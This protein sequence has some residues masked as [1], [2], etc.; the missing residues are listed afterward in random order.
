MAKYQQ[1]DRGAGND[2]DR[3]LKGMDASMRQKV[4]LTAA[5]LLCEGQIADM[6]MGSGTGSQALAALYPS[7]EVI[8]V[9][10]NQEMVDRAADRYK[11]SNLR[12]QQGDIAERCFSDQYLEA[13]LNSSVLH[14][15]TSFNGYDHSAAERALHNQ[16]KQLSYDGILITSQL[17]STLRFFHDKIIWFH[18]DLYFDRSGLVMS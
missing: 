12:F 7:L 10:I 5:H 17:R 13:I 9:D 4:A 6:G 18:T 8:G 15:V 3:Y 16:T 11:L 1:Q 14:H 2:Y